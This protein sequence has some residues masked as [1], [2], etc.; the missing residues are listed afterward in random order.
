M[1]QYRQVTF[2]D[3][4]KCLSTDICNFNDISKC[5]STDI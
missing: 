3:I 5:L 1:P 2:K 4:S